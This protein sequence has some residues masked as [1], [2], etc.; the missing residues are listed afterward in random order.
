MISMVA[1]KDTL[2]TVGEIG[3]IPGARSEGAPGIRRVSVT[4]VKID[5]RLVEDGDLFVAIKGGH[6]DGHDYVE[7]ALEKGAVAV[8]VSGPVSISKKYRDSAIIEVEDTV[9]ALG[10]LAKRY[11]SRMSAKI[12]AVTGSNGK[13]T[14]KNMIYEVLSGVAP[15]VKSQGNYNNFLGLPLSIF[16]LRDNHRYGVFELGMSA[17]GEISRLG[18]IAAPDIAVISNVGPVHLEFFDNIK[19]I[20]SAKLEILER[21]RPGGALVI[22]SD[23]ENLKDDQI[24]LIGKQRYYTV[25]VDL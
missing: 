15:S 7:S 2:F 5:S 16:Q 23:D 17:K 8:L 22:N 19:E 6:S 9:V 25:R 12:I 3:E 18:E 24:R 13:T 20:A 11:R 4:G 10:E 14:I 1:N 21:I